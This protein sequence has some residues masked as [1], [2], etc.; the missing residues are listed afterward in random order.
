MIP[1]MTASEY[2][3][4]KNVPLLVSSDPTSNIC[5]TEDIF[6]LKMAEQNAVHHSWYV[7][8]GVFALTNQN[9]PQ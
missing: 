7:S 8:I 3:R 5:S 1:S 9:S 4:I 6:Q 2:R